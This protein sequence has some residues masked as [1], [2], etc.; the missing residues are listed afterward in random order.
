MKWLE[1]SKNLWWRYGLLLAS[2]VSLAFPA[3]AA[4]Y[5]ATEYQV[6]QTWPIGSVIAVD[7]QG[8]LSLASLNNRNFIGVVVKRDAH[9]AQIADE[10]SSVSVLVSQA[11][12]DIQAGQQLGLSGVAGVAAKWQAGSPV[13][14]VAKQTPAA[15]QSTSVQA[16]DGQSQTVKLAL[17]NAQLIQA[18]G[19]SSSASESAYVGAVQKAANQIAGHSVA[20]WQ[21]S[22][23]LVLGLA[24]IVLSVGLLFISSRESFFSIGRNPLAGNTIM[25][26]LWKMSGVAVVILLVSLTSAYL[27][28]RV[29][30]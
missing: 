14:A 24:G 8:H 16:A 4:A 10:A 20:V 25:S 21:I 19:G 18:G 17:V 7:S 13:V 22:L 1:K 23:A 12:G 26:S 5:R 2:L 9:T 3:A 27:I 30:G 28:L 11:N 6:D 15:W 29:G